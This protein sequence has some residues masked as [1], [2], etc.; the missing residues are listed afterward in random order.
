MIFL[1]TDITDAASV[2]TCL[3]SCRCVCAAFSPPITDAAPCLGF[4]I[5]RQASSIRRHV[6]YMT[7]KFSFYDD[8]TVFE[9]LVS[10]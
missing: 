9:N 10:D 2:H 8:L 3:N 1:Q 4:D 7:Q 5:I 6:G